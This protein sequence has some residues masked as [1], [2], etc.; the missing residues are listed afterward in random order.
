AQLPIQSMQSPSCSAAAMRSPPGT[1]V[2]FAVV[3][4]VVP[5]VVLLPAL[6]F[7]LSSLPQ[8]AANNAKANSRATSPVPLPTRRTP[9][10]LLVSPVNGGVGRP[11][12]A[13]AGAEHNSEGSAKPA[14]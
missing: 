5:P 12:P 8:A 2:S 3:V 7:L 10:D 1:G 4:S 13:S 14:M 9:G 11:W 6:L